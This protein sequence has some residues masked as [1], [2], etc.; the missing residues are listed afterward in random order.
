MN[1]C[2][3]FIVGGVSI[4]LLL[5]LSVPVF[6]FLKNGIPVHDE[7]RVRRD[8]SKAGAKAYTLSHWLWDLIWRTGEGW[9]KL[10]R[11]SQ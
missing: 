4:F 9:G 3:F 8:E 5:Y 10:G 1:Y 11:G 2:A 7:N 6:D